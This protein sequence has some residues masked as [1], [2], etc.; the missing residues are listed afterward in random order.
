MKVG[1]KYIAAGLVV[2]VLGAAYLARR[3]QLH[4]QRYNFLKQSVGFAQAYVLPVP[5]PDLS[6]AS[7]PETTRVTAYGVSFLLPAKVKERQAMGNEAIALRLDDGRQVIVLKPSSDGAST[8]FSS[9][10]ASQQALLEDAFDVDVTGPNYGWL[11]AAFEATPNDLS[12]FRIGGRNVMTGLLLNAKRAEFVMHAKHVYEVRG[13]GARGFEV[14]VPGDGA[15]VISLQLF[16]RLDKG[17]QLWLR[18]SPAGMDWT[19]PEI[20]ALV[21]SLA[22]E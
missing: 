10:D 4:L 1:W 5:A 20:N 13:N 14:G 15:D 21:A 11:R 17:L 16:D 8:P 6:V 2:A 7:L 19:Q 3:T 12:I 9:L 18:R 22:R